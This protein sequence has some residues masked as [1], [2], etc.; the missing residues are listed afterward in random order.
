MGG[1]MSFAEEASLARRCKKTKRERFLREINTV[2]PRVRLVALIKPITPKGV[3]P[4]P[5]NA[6]CAF[7]FCSNGTN[8]RIQGWKKP[9][10]RSP[11]CG[12]SW[13][14]TWAET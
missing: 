3:S 2:V 1:Q 4:C 12:S 5:W 7:T 6:C 9:S 14:S 11:C 13:G 10:T 8:S